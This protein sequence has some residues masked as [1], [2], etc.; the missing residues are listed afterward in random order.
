MEINTSHSMASK[1]CLITGASSGV[2][3]MTALGLAKNGAHVF[4]ASRSESKALKAINFIHQRSGNPNVDYLRLD[5]ASLDSIF[6]C[7]DQF[8]KF[9]L[10][11]HILINNAG[12]FF[13][14]GLTNEGVNKIFGVNYVGH[15]LLTRL[16]LEKLENS[17]SSRIVMVSSD[18]AYR[19]NSIDWNLASISIDNH[20]FFRKFADT[21]RV[22][23]FSKFC[24]LLLM[25]ELVKRLQTQAP[26]ARKLQKQ[27]LTI[28]GVHPGFVQSNISVVHRCSKWLGLGISTA[29][30]AKSSLFCAT[31]PE[32]EGISG[33]FLGSNCQEMVL[34][35]LS[36]DSGLSYELWERSL[37]WVGWK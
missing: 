2:G 9:N 23:S 13:G 17:D 6:S 22:Y 35:E 18:A 26:Q 12:I 1:V 34:P 19:V 24:M 21:L 15:F 14:K 32:L 36:K 28:N 7:A 11:L 33:K 3:L 25:T 10:P 4:I 30:G 37:S 31:A 27:A 20:Q 16:L 8:K 29:T 5:L